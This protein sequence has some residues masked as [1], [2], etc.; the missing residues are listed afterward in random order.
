MHVIGILGGGQLAGM[1]AE[2][3]GAMGC[4]V[5][6]FERDAVSPVSSLTGYTVNGD[7]NKRDEI[8][9]FADSVDYITLENEFVDPAILGM[10]E[11][12]GHN[13]VPTSR[14]MKLIQDKLIQKQTLQNTG[15]DVPEFHAVDSPVDLPPIGDKLGYPMV[16]KRRLMSYDGKGNTWVNVEGDSHSAWE[17]LKGREGGLFAEAYCDYLCELATIIVRARDGESLHY[18]VVE[19]VQR[20]HICHKVFAPAR[21]PEELK[22]QA[23]DLAGRAVE[24]VDGIGA[25]GVEMFLMRDQR[26]LVNE[27]APRVHNSGHYTIEA[28]ETSQFENHLRVLLE[29]PL[30]SVSMR[31]PSAVMINILGSVTGSGIP[32]NMDSV[33]IPQN[34][35]LHVYG[36]AQCRPGR[37]MGHVTA[38]GDTIEEAEQ[39]AEEAAG[40]IHFE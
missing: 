38:L 28:C 34:V 33:S 35:G 2:A 13:P 36:K 14:T 7:W 40:Q 29:R 37:K 19:T 22:L 4:E 6:I 12:E 20:N 31:A 10:L 25:F 15:I 39:L 11:S 1:L 9:R 17:K 23:A 26:I 3:A 30:G 18:P 27:L 8:L 24:S 32:R 5:K 16:L 21:I